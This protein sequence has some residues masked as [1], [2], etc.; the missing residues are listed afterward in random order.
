LVPWPMVAP[1]SMMEVG[2][3]KEGNGI[4]C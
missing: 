2:C 4:M 3:W 1:W